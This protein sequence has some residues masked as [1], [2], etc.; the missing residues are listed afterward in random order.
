MSR[1]TIEVTMELKVTFRCPVCG[2]TATQDI[3]NIVNHM[4]LV[5]GEDEDTVWDEVVDEV[6]G[7]L[8]LID[9]MEVI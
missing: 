2:Y 5:H 8:S 6:N 1:Y 9:I 7:E 4:V 3:T